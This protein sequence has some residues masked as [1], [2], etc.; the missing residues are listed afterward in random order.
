MNIDDS[1]VYENSVKIIN[2]GCCHDCGGRC[3]LRAH[4]KDG[5]IIRIET[6]NDNEPQLRACEEV[7]P[8]DSEFI[9]PNDSNIL[10]GA[11]GNEEKVSLKEFHGTK[12]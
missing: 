9:L 12:H 7:E 10:Y 3:V 8:I 2:T 4:V 5:K 6:D 1:L 11:L